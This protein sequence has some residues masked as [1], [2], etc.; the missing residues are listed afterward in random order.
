MNIYCSHILYD[1]TSRNKIST[2]EVLH[3]I[4]F[5]SPQ[6]CYLR[7]LKKQNEMSTF[8]SKENL[9]SLRGSNWQTEAANVKVP[10]P[11][12]ISIIAPVAQRGSLHTEGKCVLFC[13]ILCIILVIL[14]SDTDWN[15]RS[16]RHSQVKTVPLGKSL[17]LLGPHFAHC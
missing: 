7:C 11:W 12:I 4:R 14:S 3:M 13:Y 6:E 8:T 9:I 17:A 15:C 5:L 2:D 10:D 16:L 1:T